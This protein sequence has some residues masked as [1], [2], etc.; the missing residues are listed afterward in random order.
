MLRSIQ[1]ACVV[2]L[3]ACWL[4]SLNAG[5]TQIFENGFEAGRV[6][7]GADGTDFV[8]DNGVGWCT[9]GN[10][11]GLPCP[12]AGWP[13]QDGERGRDARARAGTQN[14]IG[15]GTEGFDFTKLDALGRPLPPGAT[16]WS[17]VLDEVTGLVW[18]LKKDSPFDARDWEHRF[19]WYNPDP[20]SNG[21]HAGNVGNTTT[22]NNTLGGAACNT[23]EYV[24]HVNENGLCGYRDWRLPTRRELL[25]IVRR[26][27]VSP[28]VDTAYF[29]PFN[30]GAG[31]RYWSATPFAGGDGKVWQVGFANTGT[32]TATVGP[33]N[34]VMLVRGGALR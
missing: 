18:E 31:L 4:T 23:Y 13:G 14:K 1:A 27:A 10:Q 19:Y 15:G 24:L 25:S 26:G 5:A 29:R 17:C 11:V 30:Q 16:T 3:A 33:V 20:G 2:L 21:G 32:S 9:D 28:R 12:Q 7:G 6:G 8:N 22:C 34:L